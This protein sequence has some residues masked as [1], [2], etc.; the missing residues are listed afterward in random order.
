[1]LFLLL[2]ASPKSSHHLLYFLSVDLSCFHFLLPLL[3]VL[4]PKSLGKNFS[5][6]RFFTS[7]FLRLNALFLPFLCTFSLSQKA[8]LFHF[9]SSHLGY[10][11]TP[12]GFRRTSH[13]EQVGSGTALSWPVTA[14]GL[15]EQVCKLAIAIP[16]EKW[17]F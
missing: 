7:T 15:G 6:L 11:Q 1:M 14:G 10:S 16:G 2:P 9:S 13:L 8:S 12:L 5:L 3:N 17:A 4:T